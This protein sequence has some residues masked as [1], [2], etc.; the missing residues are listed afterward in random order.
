MALIS[1]YIVR[2]H[3]APFLF[4]TLTVLFLFLFQFILKYI[5]QLLGKVLDEWVIIQLIV[6]NLAWMVVLAVPMGVLF[7]TLMAFGSMSAANEI[8]IIKA[9]GG[10]LV[11]MMFPVVTIGILLTIL[12][13]WFNDDVLPEA[14][15]QAKILMSDIKRKKP[16]FAIE[17]GKFTTQ[18]EGY[19]ILARAMDSV[20]GVLRGVTIYDNTKGRYTNVVSAD[21]GI[22]KFTEDLS[23]L[24]M[25]LYHGEIHRIITN[26]VNNY[27][28]IKFN[29][30]RI[31]S[32]ASGFSFERSNESMTSRGDRE[33]HIADMQKIIDEASTNAKLA[34]GR[35]QEKIKK[36][37]DYLNGKQEKIN[38]IEINSQ[39]AKQLESAIDTSFEKSLSEI[40]KRMSFFR[41]MIHSDILQKN[42]FDLRIKQYT[43]EIQKKYAI[44]FAC[45]VF[46]FI[47]SP[48]GI[49]TRGGNFGVSAAITLGF[50][51]F[52]WACLIGGEKL[53]DRAYISPYLSMWIGNLAVG[54]M[55]IVLTIK[56]NNETL[57]LPF[58]K[59]FSKIFRK[60]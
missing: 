8:T 51:I 52:Y 32:S 47:G 33:M 29:K 48:L 14:N 1:K 36:H 25:Y 54:L 44:P 4:G 34:D 16:T 49:M 46:I 37:F 5:D 38:D 7:A 53:A 10:S 21:T 24:V 27:R 59:F 15:H 9:S 11:R 22:I 19:T 43:V 45:L 12:L 28:I 42:D 57:Y 18:I 31:V 40:Q 41:S 55:G 39:S 23:K 2:H 50:Y 20:S 6:L 26:N 13:F 56:V 17:S 35:I 58:S 30:F 3:I 60:K